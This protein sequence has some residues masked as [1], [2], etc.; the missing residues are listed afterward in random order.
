MKT[1]LSGATAGGVSRGGLYGSNGKNRPESP[2]PQSGKG[3]RK[4][5]VKCVKTARKFIV[6]GGEG[7]GKSLGN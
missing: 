1:L 3:V 2:L 6:K 4:N 7:Q 5:L